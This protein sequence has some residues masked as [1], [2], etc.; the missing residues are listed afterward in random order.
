MLVAVYF[1][2]RFHLK[3]GLINQTFDVLNVAVIFLSFINL[4]LLHKSVNL[5][6]HFITPLNI[7]TNLILITLYLFL[8][9]YHLRTQFPINYS[10]VAANLD[11]VNHKESWG[12]ILDILRQKDYITMAGILFFAVVIEW[13]Y[14]IFSA[15]THR[16]RL[17]HLAILPLFFSILWLSPYF[18]DEYNRFFKTVKD[19][20]FP[21]KVY[22]FN[23]KK[24]EYPLIK[25]QNSLSAPQET[26]S[27]HVFIIF[28]ESFNANFIEAVNEAGK[29]YTPTFN[30]LINEGVYFP[31]FYS[32]SVQTAKGHFATLCS[33]LPMIINKVAVDY[34]HNNFN[35]LPKI[36]KKNEYTNIFTQAFSSP[37][38]DNAQKFA[39]NLGFDLTWFMNPSLVT[40]DEWNKNVWGW[41]IQ[42]NIY[43]KTMLK[44]LDKLY[45]QNP[46]QKYFMTFATIS[47]HMKFKNVPKEQRYLYKE[48]KNKFQRYANS[49]RVADEYLN[50]FFVQL[51]QRDYLKD[52][53]VIVV[54][55]HSF[56]AGEHGSFDNEN[57]YFNEYFKTPLL[58]YWKGVL[59][60]K[61]INKLASQVDIAPT[62]LDLLQ[63]KS[64]NHFIGTSLL[65]SESDF[66][67]LI[68]PYAGT[69]L[70]VISP[71]MKKY[72]Y[73]VSSSKEIVFDL[74]TD[75]QEKNP[76]DISSLSDSERQGYQREIEKIYLNDYL[77]KVN[78]IWSEPF[79]D[80]V[81]ST[82]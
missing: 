63:I 10:V 38:F 73:H 71:E 22:S 35:C 5:I 68:Q 53:L 51:K 77:I 45:A 2:I 82:K 41:G 49:I 79:N 20:Y 44:E 19:Y 76:L 74:Q 69:Y 13:R 62:I 46:H 42:D 47:N 23:L 17:R 72:V 40:Q 61:R 66:V 3:D 7:I 75:P 64:S 8:G 57:G 37:T 27:P 25:T 24:N 18:N 26:T 14:K 30:K 11:L 80:L 52:S 39:S 54:G 29:E 81:I 6:T 21:N 28:E 34:P 4:Y 16:F 58:I 32:N 60:P 43:F 78:Q 1:I 48:Q 55:D 15:N 67:H 59:Q 9:N 33:L 56:P 70:A 65:S 36:L 12:V 31:N 50:E